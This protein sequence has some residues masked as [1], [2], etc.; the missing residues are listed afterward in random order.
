MSSSPQ[1][2]SSRE[3]KRRVQSDGGQIWCDDVT[4]SLQRRYEEAAISFRRYTLPAGQSAGL[5]GCSTNN[6]KSDINT[7]PAQNLTIRNTVW[8]DLPPLHTYYSVNCH[9][10]IAILLPGWDWIYYF[11]LLCSLY[12]TVRSLGKW[13]LRVAAHISWPSNGRLSS[14]SGA[15]IS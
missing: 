9:R 2:L 11:R 15:R 4:Q 10:L 6:K 5:G 13:F 7:A 8:T 14:V 12:F 3:R 1:R